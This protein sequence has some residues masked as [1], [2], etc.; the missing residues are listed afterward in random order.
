MYLSAASQHIYGLENIANVQYMSYSALVNPSEMKEK[1]LFLI[2]LPDLGPQ[3]GALKLN[4]T[5][6][7]L[8]VFSFC[9]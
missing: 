2:T 3:L 5:F 6:L 1:G 8:L 4:F 9:A 7:S